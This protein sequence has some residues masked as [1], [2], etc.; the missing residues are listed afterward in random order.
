MNNLEKFDDKTTLKLTKTD[1]INKEKMRRGFRLNNYINIF[2]QKLRADWL[3]YLENDQ[4]CQRNWYLIQH[5]RIHLP[6]H[7][8]SPPSGS[9]KKSA[10]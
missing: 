3:K 6:T 2:G 4:T 9:S 10:K 5:N 7:D 8:A 1:T